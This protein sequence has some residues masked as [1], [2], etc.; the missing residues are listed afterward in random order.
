MVSPTYQSITPT[1]QVKNTVD[2]DGVSHQG[3][4]QYYR[5]AFSKE[6]FDILS[7]YNFTNATYDYCPGECWPDNKSGEHSLFIY[8]TQ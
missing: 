6:G 3:S 8:S 4:L 1:N 5:D 2:N 7:E